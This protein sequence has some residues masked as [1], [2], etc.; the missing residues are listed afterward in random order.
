MVVSLGMFEDVY[1]I[2]KIYRCKALNALKPVDCQRTFSMDGLRSESR[3]AWPNGERTGLPN[4][5]TRFE[6]QLGRYSTP[7]L[8][9]ILCNACSVMR[10]FKNHYI[11]C[12]VTGP[13]TS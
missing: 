9:N 4:Q 3:P 12:T 8:R 5:R 1:Y 2:S 11:K 13:I 6:S 7:S 10:A